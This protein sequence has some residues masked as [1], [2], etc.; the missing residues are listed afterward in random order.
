[1]I[2]AL[3]AVLLLAGGWYYYFQMEAEDG[4]P[5]KEK[6]EDIVSPEE[7]EK[8]ER[9]DYYKGAEEV[10]PEEGLATALDNDFRE[11]LEKV[12]EGEPKLTDTGDMT[13]LS[14]V[15]KR[16]ITND[17]AS[18]IKGLVEMKEGYNIEGVGG[19]D[20]YYELK[21]L[22]KMEEE[23]YEGDLRVR[24]YTKEERGENVQKI[25]VLLFEK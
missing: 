22:G 9:K 17:D 2:I 4:E 6:E 10:S 23:G 7:E 8:I 5:S 15:V 25:E 19:K 14:Y 24:I 1:M 21:L 11:I 13:L 12:F 18:R 16:P 3:G 20:D